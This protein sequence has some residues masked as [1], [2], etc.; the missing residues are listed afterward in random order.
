MVK[1]V[2]ASSLFNYE[3]PP[4]LTYTPLETRAMILIAGCRVAERS[5]QKDPAR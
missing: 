4:S 1:K 2:I 3:W 5:I